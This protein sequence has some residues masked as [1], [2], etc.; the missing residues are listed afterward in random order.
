MILY[1]AIDLKQGRA[2]QLQQGEM[3]RASEYGD[4]LTIAH[5]YAA[6]G[7]K[8]LH[9][10]DLDGA[11]GKG[12]NQE[13][14]QQIAALGL[15]QVQTGGGI[16]TADDVL[17]RLSWGVQ[18]VIVGTMALENPNLVRELATAHPGRIAL[19]LDAREGKVATRG[20]AVQTDV[21]ALDTALSF[22][23][24]GID[25][26]IYTDIAR[27]G[28]LSGPN[29][30]ELRRMVQDCGMQVIASGGISSLKDIANCAAAGSAGCIVGTALYEGKFTTIQ[31]LEVCHGT[32]I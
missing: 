8:W 26:V 9:V 5:A 29:L 3:H 32:E 12:S 21:T 20:W 1:P 25:T 27:D 15:Q 19:G 7:A 14:L 2:V 6:D 10:V 16:R 13:I 17:R 23:G 4:P 11:F 28:M 22:A 18:R 24:C 30:G 31:A